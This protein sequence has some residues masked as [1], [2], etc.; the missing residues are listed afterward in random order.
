MDNYGLRISQRRK[1]LGM[2]QSDLA[3]VAGVSVSLV[4]QIEQGKVPLTDKTAAALAAAL[5]VD[6]QYLIGESDSA[7]R[8]FKEE[9]RLVLDLAMTAIRLDGFSIQQGENDGSLSGLFNSRK[10]TLTRPGTDPFT[11]TDG[12][13][14]RI[15][16]SLF[17]NFQ[18]LSKWIYPTRLGGYFH[19][20]E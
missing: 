10:F 9:T 18:T 2:K 7:T 13:L 14:L 4:S 17:E 11:V 16:N 6:P 19:K 3:A 1:S 5:D 8:D 12:D 15:G 20:T